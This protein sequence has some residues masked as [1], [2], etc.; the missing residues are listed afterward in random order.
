MLLNRQIILVFLCLSL[1]GIAQQTQLLTSNKKVGIV[2][3]GGGAKG[4][5]HIGVLKVI[6][7]LGIKIDYIAGTSMGAIV[8]GLYASGYTAKQLDS[9]FSQA[10]FDLIIGDK[11]P[12]RIKTL[13]KLSFSEKHA[14]SLPF[15]NFKLKLPKGIS[16]G[17]N[18]INLYTQFTFHVNHI[19]DF[20]KLPI[21]F[22]C[23]ATDVETGQ[24]VVLDKGNLPRA[25]AASAAFPSLF[26]PVRINQQFLIDGGVVNNYPIDELKA[27][28]IDIII[29]VD[30]QDDLLKEKDIKGASD[31]LGQLSNYQNTKQML[32][33][34]KQTDIY[35]KP[36]ITNFNIISFDQR[37]QIVNAGKTAALHKLNLLKNFKLKSKTSSKPLVSIKATDTFNITNVTIKGNANYTGDYIAKLLNINTPKITYADFSKGVKN[38]YATEN[39]ENITYDFK[40]TGNGYAITINVK[41]IKSKLTL[42][43]GL[44]YDN[45][46]KTAGLLNVTKTKLLLDNDMASFDLIVGDNFR[47]NFEYF[48]DF[49]FLGLGV[50]SRFTAFNKAVMPEIYISDTQISDRLN[51]LNIDIS[52]QT[53]RFFLQSF[54]GKNSL[55]N[56]GFEYKRLNIISET[57]L[58]LNRD[59]AE[60]EK[61]DFFSVFANL[62]LDT[63]DDKFFPTKG[64]FFE[65]DFHWYFNSSNFNDNFSPFAIIK[66]NFRYVKSFFDDKLSTSINLQ[67]GF[68]IGNDTNQS[69]NFALGGYGNHL[70]NNYVPFYGY[71]FIALTG[72]SFG[73]IGTTINWN[74]FEKGHLNFSAN[75]ANVGDR[76]FTNHA[77]FKP[78]FTG[79]ALGYGHETIIG[80]AE[81]KLSWSPEDDSKAQLF[82]SIGYWF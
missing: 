51:L 54:S 74:V 60:F 71:D 62:K 17:H 12:R 32:V 31:I 3:S 81:I 55:L 13:N 46:Y 2:L 41:E 4:F 14:F 21:P 69:L 5:A 44:H 79:Y 9:M 65:N 82:L 40:P 25:I 30:V 15:D 35:I 42:N 16:K 48:V 67:A 38:L 10:T 52:D 28:G 50:S 56:T 11:I 72:N 24:Q 19:S 66:S 77:T 76:V 53:N 33:K 39:F 37:E 49:G 47:Y 80:P 70:I 63:F 78:E 7:S 68:K 8:G 57:I 61:S 20:K 18:L 58:S 43:L 75:V 73:K 6:D 1:N 26:E 22:F 23:I 45:L 59:I 27:K 36:D 34:A 64:V 29:G